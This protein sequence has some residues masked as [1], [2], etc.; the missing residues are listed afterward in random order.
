V[1]EGAGTQSTVFVEAVVCFACPTE[2]ASCISRS[3]SAFE[4]RVVR[5]KQDTSCEICSR[6]WLSELLGIDGMS[7]A[8]L[9]DSHHF[10][11]VG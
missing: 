9:Q 11:V 7:A 1:D 2:V 4:R 6:R 10:F 5:K 3:L 8:Q